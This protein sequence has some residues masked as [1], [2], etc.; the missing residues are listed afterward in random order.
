[1]VAQVVEHGEAGEAGADDEYI[2]LG[3]GLVAGASWH[4]VIGVGHSKAFLPVL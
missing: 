3:G 1:L 4:L 2:E